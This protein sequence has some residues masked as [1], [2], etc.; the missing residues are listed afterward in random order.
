[1]CV[2][3]GLTSSSFIQS[4]G[5]LCFLFSLHFLKIFFFLNLKIEL[6]REESYHSRRVLPSAGSRLK[7]AVAARS[8]PDCSQDRRTPSGSPMGG[9]GPSTWLPSTAFRGALEESWICSGTA[10]TPTSS[11]T[12]LNPLRHDAVSPTLFILKCITLSPSGSHSFK[13]HSQVTASPL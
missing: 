7:M 12:Q 8:G 13:R 6:Q 10:G 1:M 4:Q 3:P 2:C 5:L 9:R 11:H